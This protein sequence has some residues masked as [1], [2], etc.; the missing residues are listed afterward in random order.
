MLFV[1]G[2]PLMTRCDF[3]VAISLSNISSKV[4][5][6]AQ[7]SIRE[8]VCLPPISDEALLLS[9][10]PGQGSQ[11]AGRKIRGNIY[12]NHLIKGQ[13]IESYFKKSDILYDSFQN[14]INESSILV[15]NI[16]NKFLVTCFVIFITGF[17]PPL[18]KESQLPD[19][20]FYF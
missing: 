2:C 19:F 15:L 11:A 12:Y 18:K 7:S 17:I 8:L 4:H 20:Y 10:H 1:L 5:A 13:I 14:Q 16:W 9:M 3:S 6:Q